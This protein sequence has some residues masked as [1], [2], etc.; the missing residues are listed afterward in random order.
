VRNLYLQIFGTI[1]GTSLPP[2]SFSR[3]QTVH[4]FKED[5]D[6]AINMEGPLASVKTMLERLSKENVEKDAKI[7]HQNK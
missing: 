2:I 7:K 4:S 3:R 1:G 6:Q 5:M